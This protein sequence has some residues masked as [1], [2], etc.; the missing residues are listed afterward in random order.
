MP[1]TVD[2]KYLKSLLD[3]HKQ[4]YS[5]L[6][7]WLYL[8]VNSDA[9]GKLNYSLKKI[10][11]DFKWSIGKVRLFLDGKKDIIKRDKN[12]L[13]INNIDSCKIKVQKGK[14]K[15]QETTIEKP[16][17]YIDQIVDIFAEE[18]LNEYRIDYVI[19]SKEKNRSAAS[20]ILSDYKKTYK[21]SNSENTLIGLRNFFRIAVKVKDEWLQKNMSLPIIWSK[22][23]FI[24]KSCRNGQY[25]RTESEQSDE[26]ASIVD[27]VFNATGNK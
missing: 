14:A 4:P 15:K 7:A 11:D 20:R 18:Y 27:S 24:K 1:A 19:E 12:C 17:D 8:I 2:V 22:Y 21:F 16:K 26:I 13:V 5:K 9:D 6:E 10:A 25:R 23:N 3:N